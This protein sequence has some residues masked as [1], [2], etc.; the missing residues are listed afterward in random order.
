MRIP[1]YN[2]GLGPTV[3]LAVGQSGPR[4]NVSTFTAPSRA[5]AQFADQAG[6]IAFRFGMAEKARETERVATKEATR[7]QA[8]S[9]NFLLQNQD[10][11]TAVFTENFTKFQNE[12]LNKINTLPNLTNQQ[13]EDVAARASKVLAGKLAAGKQNTFNRGTA[14]ASDAANESIAANIAEMGTLS[15]DDPRYIELYNTNIETINKGIANGLKLN[16]TPRS[17]TLSATS[18]NYYNQIEAASSVSALDQIKNQLKTDKTLPTKIYQALLRN[19]SVRKN[20]IKA[21]ILEAAKGQI[22]AYAEK[23]SPDQLD[24][25][26]SANLNNTPITLNIDGEDVTYDPSALTNTGRLAMAGLSQKLQNQAVAEIAD[27]LTGRISEISDDTTRASLMQA[28]EDAADGKNFTITRTNGE[29]E[30][31]DISQL[32]AGMQVKVASVLGK[33]AAELADFSSREAVNGMLDVFQ[34][35]PSPEDAFNTFQGFYKPDELAKLGLD[36]EQLDTLVY[37]SANISVDDVTRKISEGDFSNVPQ[38]LRTLTTAETLLTQNLDGRGSLQ[39]HVDLNLASNVSVT[40]N[41]ISRARG[42]IKTEVDKIAKI[43]VGVKQL[44]SGG[45]VPSMFTA[46]ETK[47]IVA[48]TIAAIDKEAVATNKNSMSEKFNMLERNNVVHLPYKDELGKITSLGRSGVL[49]VG[50][51]DFESV[52]RGLN[53]YNAMKRYPRVLQNHTTADDRTFFDAINHRLG[54]E[55]LERAIVNVSTAAFKNIEIPSATNKQI[56]QA[57]NEVMDK[58]EDNFIGSMFM[59]APTEVQNSSEIQNTLTKR[60]KDYV[61][62]GIGVDTAIDL[63]KKDIS[64]THVFVRGILTR[65]QL[66]TPPNINQ[67]ADLAVEQAITFRDE[68]RPGV[69][70]MADDALEADDLSLIEVPTAGSGVWALV[71]AG[72]VSVQ[73]VTKDTGLISMIT[74]TTAELQQLANDRQEELDKARRDKINEEE[75]EAAAAIAMGIVTNEALANFQGVYGPYEYTGTAGEKAAAE[76]AEQAR[77]RHLRELQELIS[78]AMDAQVQES[79]SMQGGA[80]YSLPSNSGN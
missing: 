26:A 27:S 46:P 12:Q 68:Q 15:P 16:Y 4:A 23:A 48:A 38:L 34:S 8:E 45:F 57:T 25:L 65:K 9:D 51:A 18:R 36:S 60:V 11:D 17:M 70:I 69:P 59:D 39:T 64:E 19:V 58:S 22:A 52:Q 3:D 24:A 32:P 44:K 56:E 78:M 33:A 28:S 37:N 43:N 13:K 10:T 67:L 41:A 49:E 73:G 31:F 61:S 29:V 71:Y 5:A 6:Q 74:W 40:L 47:K 75:K 54:Y 20:D 80:M 79:M 7:I 53:F 66:N 21:D 1:L 2:K 77:Q 63:A 72:G 55:T 30:E 76:T 42:H 50:T 14:M 35:D 62:L